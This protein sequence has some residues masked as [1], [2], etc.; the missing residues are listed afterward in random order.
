MTTKLPLIILSLVILIAAN[1]GFQV[2]GRS[3][4]A[5][6]GEVWTVT[7]VLSGQTVAVKSSD[8]KTKRIRLQGIT[9]PLKQQEPWGNLARQRLQQLVQDQPIILESPH[10]DQDDRPTA[11]IWQG[12]TL[13]NAQLIKEGY[14]LVDTFAPNS[15]YENKLKMLQS[16]ARL[17]ELGIW[18]P[19]NPMRIHPRDLRRQILR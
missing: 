16:E 2:W 12:N 4:Q 15:K 7:R 6:S 13:I 5:P 18:D 10:I 9:A 19:Q 1:F 3:E 8:G 14:V 17:L 11:Y